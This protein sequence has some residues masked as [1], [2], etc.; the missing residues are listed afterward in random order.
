MGETQ[1][2]VKLGIVPESLVHAGHADEDHRQVGSLWLPRRRSS[3]VVL[4]R[5]ASSMTSSSTR[6]CGTEFVQRPD[7]GTANAYFESHGITA[8]GV[9]TDNGS[10]NRSYALE[11]ALGAAFKHKRTRPYLPRAKAKSRH[12]TAPLSTN[13]PAPVLTDQRLERVA[14]F[15]AWLHHYNYA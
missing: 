12:T 4:G 5:S 11:D 14:D 7:S 3:A 1:A 15:P 6:S 13:V 10:C 8:K 2:A 9:L